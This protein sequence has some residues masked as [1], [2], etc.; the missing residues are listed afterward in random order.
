MIIFYNLNGTLKEKLLLNNTNIAKVNGVMIK[1][2]LKNGEIVNGIADVFKSCKREEYSLQVKDFIYLSLW[3]NLDEETHQ[4]LGNTI[5]EQ[6][7][8][9]YEKVF[10]SDIKRI[11]AII[12]SGPR[13]GG[14]LTNKFQFI[15]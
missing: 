8:R 5:E 10:I 4:L 1:C 15:S 14:K 2:Y 13:W 3:K 9:T 11:E 12:H 6:Y 7:E